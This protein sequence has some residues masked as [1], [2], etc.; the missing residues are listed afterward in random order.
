MEG[1]GIF[2]PITTLGA[3]IFFI[4]SLLFLNIYA[5]FTVLVTAEDSVGGLEGFSGLIW[6]VLSNACSEVL[7]NII[8]WM[9]F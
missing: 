7:A 6:L 1:E 5:A 4:I 9:V 2:L 3:I 8:V